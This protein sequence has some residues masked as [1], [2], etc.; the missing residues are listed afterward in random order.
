METTTPRPV[1]PAVKP[2]VLRTMLQEDLTVKIRFY[3]GEP[4][5]QGWRKER[6]G[7]LVRATD[8]E[9]TCLNSRGQDV[10]IPVED[11]FGALIGE[12]VM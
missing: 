7:T 2:Y 3:F 5:A 4:D 12:V 8:R 1:L 11:V 10:K 9:A 6:Q